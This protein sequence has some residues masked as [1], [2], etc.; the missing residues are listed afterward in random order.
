[1]L[2]LKRIAVFL[3]LPLGVWSGGCGSSPTAPSA[4]AANYAGEWSGTTAQG[5]PITFTVSGDAKVTS[6]VVGYSF[7]GCSGS[8]TFSNLNLETAAMVECIPGP[9][10]ASLSTFRSFSHLTGSIDG[11]MTTVNGLLYSTTTAEGAV[12]FRNYP[13]CGT[14]LGIAWTATKR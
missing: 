14:A 10:P 4:R 8:Q 3:A 6:I 5:R 9:C 12:G 11:P 2:V 7:N 13:G 1:M